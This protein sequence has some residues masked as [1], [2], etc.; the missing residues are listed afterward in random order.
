MAKG[1][2]VNWDNAPIGKEAFIGLIIFISGLV[3]EGFY[4][5]NRFLGLEN[6]M[7]EAN[8]KIENLLSKH[9]ETEEEEFDRLE[10]EIAWYQKELQVNPF[11]WG[12][13]K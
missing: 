6:D 9:I 10:K 12:K 11:R 7:I 1:S 8:D 5:Y 2:F 3:G 13:K 4:F